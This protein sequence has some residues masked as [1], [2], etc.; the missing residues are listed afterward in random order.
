MQKSATE[1]PCTT[2]C[3]PTFK[4]R[5]RTTDYTVGVYFSVT[6]KESI[7][8]KVLRLIKGDIAKSHESKPQ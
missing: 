8:A 6:A 7:N 3:N 5:I 2:K 1:K 4:K